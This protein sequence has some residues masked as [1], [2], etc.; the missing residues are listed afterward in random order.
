LLHGALGGITGAALSKDVTQGLMSG[1]LG[2]MAA[3]TIAEFLAPTLEESSKRIEDL[4]AQGRPIDPAMLTQ[5]FM[6]AQGRAASWGKFSSALTALLV[7]ADVNIAAH[8]GANAVDHNFLLPVLVVA[9]V[10][11]SACEV[12]NAYEKEGL[13]GA[14]KQLG[15]EVAYTIVG[16]AAVKVAIY[17]GGRWVVPVAIRYG[18]KPFTSLEEA[19]TAALKDQPALKLALGKLGPLLEK[20][21]GS[22][23]GTSEKISVSRPASSPYYSTEFL[24]TLK[25][26][27]HYPGKSDRVH[28]QEVNKQLFETLKLDSRMAQQFESRYP[29]IMEFLTPSVK[30]V[31]PSIP[32][33]K[34]GLT[35]HHNA[36]LPGVL[37]LI[38]RVQH[39][40][41]G[42]VQNNLH[43]NRKGGM[44]NWGGGRKKINSKVQNHE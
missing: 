31:F 8:T 36:R 18:A 25:Q 37:E 24:V 20:G 19:F 41:P 16:G 42:P 13:L 27:V 43:P 15:I 6:D 3:E 12:T 35:W 44:E 17:M 28:F 21:K 30:G 34:F 32:P 14:A 4:V 7:G 29:G 26:K 9:G 1:A 5:D 38:P 39:R 22:L 11:Y 2:A 40:A 33:V 10:V 23:R